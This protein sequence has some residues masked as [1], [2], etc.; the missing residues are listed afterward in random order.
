VLPQNV[1]SRPRYVSVYK[2]ALQEARI[3]SHITY[4]NPIKRLFIKTTFINVST[5]ASLRPKA[6]NAHFPFTYNSFTTACSQ[7]GVLHSSDHSNSQKHPVSTFKLSETPCIKS[8]DN[9]VDKITRP[10]HKSHPTDI[11]QFQTFKVKNT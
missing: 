3:C 11:L 4:R 1:K 6:K 10:G 7:R 9:F 2:N 5:F 8:L